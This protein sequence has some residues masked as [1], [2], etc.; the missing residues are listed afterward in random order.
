MIKLS[1]VILSALLVGCASKQPDPVLV[2]VP[3]QAS[4]P[5]VNRA[6]SLDDAT[7]NERYSIDVKACNQVAQDTAT[8]AKEC[9]TLKG[10]ENIQ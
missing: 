8:S 7:Q 6:Y 1:A 9:M 2:E 10:W 4:G 3:V 5:V